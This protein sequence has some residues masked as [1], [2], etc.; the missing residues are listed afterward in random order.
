MFQDIEPMHLCDT[1]D[2]R[3]PDSGESQLE[4]YELSEAEWVDYGRLWDES[5]GISLPRDMAAHFRMERQK[6]FERI[7]KIR[8]I[9]LYSYRNMIQSP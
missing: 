7:L 1:Y 4:E 6:E 3:Q 5:G 2:G 8:L 9:L